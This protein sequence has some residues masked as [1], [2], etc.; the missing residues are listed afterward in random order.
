[1]S[2]RVKPFDRIFEGV[3]R[4]QNSS[5][6]VVATKKDQKEFQRRDD[7]LTKLYENGQLEVLRAF[8][9]GRLSIQ[10]LVEASREEMLK[11]AGLLADLKLR[12]R[13][14]H[15]DA[16]CP[17]LLQHNATLDHSGECV[18][19][20]DLMLPRM[21]R[22][23][24][25]R[26]RYETSLKKLQTSGVLPPNACVADLADVDW[27]A[28]RE[29]WW[30]GSA[31][32]WNHLGRALSRFLALHLSK[33]ASG[34][35]RTGKHHPFR[36]DVMDSFEMED[37]GEGRVP[38]VTVD[39]FWKIVMKTPE[40]ARPCYVGLVITGNRIGEYL[41]IGEEHHN[42][43]ACSVKIPD[44]KTGYRTI[45]YAQSVRKWMA[46]AIPSPL[47]YGW[48][49]KY[50]ID[51]CI[52]LGFG[53]RVEDPLRPGKTIYQGLRLHDLRHLHAQWATDEGIAEAAVGDSLGHKD[54]RMTRRYTRQ[55]N[56]G[57]VAEAVGRAMTRTS[58]KKVS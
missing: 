51:A 56:R 12:A 36:L 49:R 23:P 9:E 41:Q 11:K 2:R 1:M 43:D 38:D 18:G 5:G 26:R 47:Q 25:T 35:A 58:L 44:G 54:P 40:H 16:Q 22:S 19:S 53:E 7:I 48:L 20:V 34:T 37:E 27:R 29:D 6:I 15:D 14:W 13:L 8:K 24:N 39:Q 42:P 10:Q 30:I 31:A 28:L 17:K 46:R 32:D 3:G 4:I 57:Q 33:K 52:E 55:K 21:G 45:R 50:F